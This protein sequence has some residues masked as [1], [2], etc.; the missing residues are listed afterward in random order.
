MRL[1]ISLELADGS[2]W[3]D[4]QK[5]VAGAAPANAKLDVVPILALVDSYGAKGIITAVD[6]TAALN[7]GSHKSTW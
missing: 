2:T 6:E 7:Y 5:A 1:I 3:E 4:V